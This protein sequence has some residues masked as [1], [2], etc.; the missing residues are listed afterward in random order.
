MTDKKFKKRLKYHMRN[1]G[2]L[3]SISGQNHYQDTGAG[4]LKCL[5]SQTVKATILAPKFGATLEFEATYHGPKTAYD[6]LINFLDKIE[7]I[8]S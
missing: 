2:I 6:Q 1:G 4:S 3:S 8:V 7:K 5:V